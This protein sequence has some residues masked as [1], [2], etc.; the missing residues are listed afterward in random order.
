MG[1]ARE[2]YDTLEGQGLPTVRQLSV[3]LDNRLGQLLR[4]TQI[5]EQKDVKILGLS[6]SESVDC[7]IIRLIFDSPD[8]AREVLRQAGFAV[9]VSE[10]IVVRLPPGKRGL[11]TVWQC[12][13]SS[14]VNVGYCYPLLPE[15]LGSAIA[16][17]VD[18]FEIAT[19]T[20]IRYKL[21]VLGEDDLGGEP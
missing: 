20:L 15:T 6:V 4:L 7:G 3:F 2:P 17:S 18:N 14:E 9:S 13:L 12:L 21:D 1:M 5:I 11:L 8:E 19:D 10:V 16:L